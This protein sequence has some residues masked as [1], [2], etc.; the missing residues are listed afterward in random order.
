MPLNL[1]D[2]VNAAPTPDEPWLVADIGGTN[3]R[4]GA[5]FAGGQ[6]V[7]YVESLLVAEHSGPADAVSAYLDQLAQSIG[8]QQYRAPRRAAFAVATAVLGDEIDFTNS[9]WKFSRSAVQSALR[10]DSLLALNDFE[11]LALSL[12]HLCASQVRAHGGIPASSGTL[13]V[14]GPGTGLGV[15]GVK[16]IEH[17]WVAIP[18]E[19]GHAT[20]SASD[21]FESALL[22]SVRGR[23][24]HVSAERLLSGIG[25]PVLHRAVSEVIGVASMERT[26]QQIITDG[27]ARNDVVCERTLDV[28]CSLLGGFCGNVALTLGARSGLYVGGGIVP[29][30]GDR[31]FT[32][33]FRQ[34]FVAKGRFEAY[35]DAIPTAVIMDTHAALTGAAAAIAQSCQ[36]FCRDIS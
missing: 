15:A 4:F 5:V 20:L 19:G 22:T 18:G 28:F 13:A 7:E 24:A 33:S 36:P 14:V 21:A 32:S 30:L 29:R 17:G 12:P 31:F 16:Q 35:L 11:A 2:A 34:R 26:A 6:G 10:L 25:L 8:R 9:A 23:N 27:L 1:R 3:A